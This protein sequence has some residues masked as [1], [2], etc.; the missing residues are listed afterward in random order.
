VYLAPKLEENLEMA[1]AKP[2][3]MDQ[4]LPDKYNNET[5]T[6]IVCSLVEGENSFAVELKK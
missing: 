6:D 3:Y 5:T 1:E 2:V 4:A